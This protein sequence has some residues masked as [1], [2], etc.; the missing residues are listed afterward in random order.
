MGDDGGDAHVDIAPAPATFS[1][2]R[3]IPRTDSLPIMT[4]RPGLASGAQTPSSAFFGGNRGSR[5]IIEFDEYFVRLHVC[6]W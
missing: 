1:P 4:P 3:H 5:H 2:K 6:F